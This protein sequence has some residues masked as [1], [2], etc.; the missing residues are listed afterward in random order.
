MFGICSIKPFDTATATHISVP[1]AGKNRAYPSGRSIGLLSFT[2]YESPNKASHT[3]T[4][5]SS[6]AIAMV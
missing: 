6:M 4:F 3:V 2:P 5:N 1:Q